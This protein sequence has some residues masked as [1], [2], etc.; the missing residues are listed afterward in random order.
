MT[1]LEKNTILDFVSSDI[2]VEKFYKILPQYIN[3]DF[4]INEYSKTIIEKDSETLSYLRMIPISNF[5]NFE[6]IY[7]KLLI[8]NWHIENEDI[9]SFFQNIFN[10]NKDNIIFLLK[11]LE[12]I[13]EYLKVDN[14]TKLSYIKKIIYAIGA[15]PQPESLLALEKLAS[16]T[17]DE[18]IKKLAL[19]QIEKRKR[20][21]R[22]EFNS[23]NNE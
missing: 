15:Q 21:G 8:E 2:S 4:I 20:L 22:W 7:Q 23:K 5:E 19:H 18:E 10:E 12:N 3:E 14:I 6:K 1:E 17:N 11:A 13:P 16:E 9:V